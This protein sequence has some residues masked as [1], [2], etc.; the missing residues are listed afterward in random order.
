[1]S[2]PTPTPPPLSS[3]I[4]STVDP[5]LVGLHHVNNGLLRLGNTVETSL[6]PALSQLDPGGIRRDIIG[7]GLQEIAG[8]SRR[9]KQMEQEA[10]AAL[11]ILRGL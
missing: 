7:D 4:L 9:L 5:P 3:F 8:Q 10:Q 1:M 11:T 2:I 6:M